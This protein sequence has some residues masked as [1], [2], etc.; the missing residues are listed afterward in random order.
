M[1][2]P[3]PQHM[4]HNDLSLNWKNLQS[5]RTVPAASAKNNILMMYICFEILIFLQGLNLKSIMGVCV[6]GAG[7]IISM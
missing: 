5:S 4:I 6:C 3:V 2:I 1:H 7:L